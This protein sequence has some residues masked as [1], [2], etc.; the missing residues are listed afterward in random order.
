[1]VIRFFPGLLLSPY[2][3]TLPDEEDINAARGPG[4]R[5]LHVEIELST[6]ELADASSEARQP[7][8]IEGEK[9]GHGE[10]ASSHSLAEFVS[11][12]VG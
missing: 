7:R 4:N 6:V 5:R 2:P 1:M 10:A 12:K 3:S 11:V 9:A 8:T